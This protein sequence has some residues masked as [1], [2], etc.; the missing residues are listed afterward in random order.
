MDEPCLWMVIPSNLADRR[1]VVATQNCPGIE[2]HYP[3]NPVME[4]SPE[5]QDSANSDNS[6]AITR[7]GWYF[8]VDCVLASLQCNFCF[9]IQ[10]F[11]QIH[12][13]KNISYK[14]FVLDLCFPRSVLSTDFY[15]MDII[16]SNFLSD[17]WIKV[18][19]NLKFHWY[20]NI[21]V[22]SILLFK[23]H[24]CFFFIE[25]MFMF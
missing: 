23:Y 10:L 5:S 24:V 1:I 16:I 6:W 13:V 21:Y 11:I 17:C 3:S 9:Y 2:A 14:S 22:I 8:R 20:V 19:S 4:K 12:S 15:F 18:E 7:A 25:T